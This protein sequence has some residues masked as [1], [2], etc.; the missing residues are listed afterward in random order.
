MRSPSYVHYSVKVIPS[1]SKCLSRAIHNLWI[2]DHV[3]SIE[4]DY[5][6]SNFPKGVKRHFCV[7]WHWIFDNDIQTF[8]GLVKRNR[9]KIA[10]VK[11]VLVWVFGDDK[12]PMLFE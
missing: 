11:L 3:F 2:T 4:V 1:I 6:I 5:F 9:D 8:A 7:R 10:R 12:R